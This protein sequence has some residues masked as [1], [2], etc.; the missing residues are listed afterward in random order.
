MQPG[1]KIEFKQTKVTDNRKTTAIGVAA[2]IAGSLLIAS[3]TS[4][5]LG[6]GVGIVA[7]GIIISI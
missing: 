3:A 6:V 1:E 5:A 2:V 4:M 7:F